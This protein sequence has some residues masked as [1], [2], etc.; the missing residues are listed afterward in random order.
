MQ[1]WMTNSVLFN[2]AGG[3]ILLTVVG[4]MALD[5]LRSGKVAPCSARFPAGR[6][7]A[8]DSNEGHALT[9]I[10]LQGRAG[11]RQWGLLQNASVETSQSGK[12]V[13]VLAVKLAPTGSEENAN[14]NGVGFVWPLSEVEKAGAVCLSYYV[15]FPKDFGF[16]EPGYLPGIYGAA[17]PVDLDAAERGETFA[18]RVGWG[19]NGDIGG[20]ILQPGKPRYWFGAKYKTPWPAGRWAKVEQEVVLNHPGKTDG[21]LRIW[22]NDE[23]K[24]ANTEMAFRTADK[25]GFSGV[26]GDIGYARTASDPAVIRVSPFVVRWH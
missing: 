7:L 5:F 22:V 24:T 26:V 13:S 2:L 19:P 12:T 20:E 8:L 15:A 17:L 18:T 3:A 6:Q 4:Y 23:L 14:Q 25:A 1:R 21:I 16:D 11:E 10:E 9:P